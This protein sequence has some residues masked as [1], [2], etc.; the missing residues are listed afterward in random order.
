MNKLRVTWRNI[1]NLILNNKNLTYPEKIEFKNKTING[2]KNVC[3][4]FAFFFENYPIE[5]N[6]SINISDKSYNSY[7]PRAISCFYLY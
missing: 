1:N 2:P 7:F 6:N 5:L 3:D 4:A